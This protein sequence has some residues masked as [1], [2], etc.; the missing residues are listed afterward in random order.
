[1]IGN[2]VD[3]RAAAP[4]EPIGSS[5][6]WTSPTRCIANTWRDAMRHRALPEFALYVALQMLER[7]RIVNIGI[8]TDVVDRERSAR[9]RGVVA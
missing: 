7:L 4:T 9:Q 5:E 8:R 6:N 1:M 3:V 2:A